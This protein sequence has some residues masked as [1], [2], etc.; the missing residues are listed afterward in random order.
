MNSNITVQSTGGDVVFNAGDNV[1]I[2]GGATV[3]AV[4]SDTGN[5]TFNSGVADSDNIGLQALDGTI[6]ASAGTVTLN[7]NEEAGPASQANTGTITAN[8]LRLLSIANG[9]GSFSLGTSATNNASTL[10]AASDGSIF[11]RDADGLTVGTLG[12]TTGITTSDDD[13]KLIVDAN[14]LDVDE[15]I[16]LGTGNLFLDVTGNVTQQGGDDITAGGLALMVDGTTRLDNAGN[17]VTNFAADND[18][19]TVYR[20]ADTLNVESITVDG[21]TVTGISTTNDDVTINVLAGNLNLL[22]AV[23]TRGGNLQATATADITSSVAG[24]VTTTGTIANQDS[25][26]VQLTGG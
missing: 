14:D 24:T 1:V 16:A 4:V 20:D 15:E 7:L 12:A 19:Q 21:M 18:D 25:G 11:Y 26:T 10:A 9:G 17:N 6:T 22:L 2:T 3:A 13:V 5:V 23:N 8:I